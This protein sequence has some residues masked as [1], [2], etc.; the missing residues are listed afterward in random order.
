VA[1]VMAFP[2]LNADAAGPTP[3]TPVT[4]MAA[5]VK[6][7]PRCPSSTNAWKDPSAQTLELVPL[8]VAVAPLAGSIVQ[9]AADVGLNWIKERR[10]TLS[11]TTSARDDSTFYLER[12]SG[13]VA[14]NGCLI[15]ARGE[16]GSDAEFLRRQEARQF[17]SDPIWTGSRIR[18]LRN[19]WDNERVDQEGDIRRGRIPLVS[20]PMI[21]AEFSIRYDDLKHAKAFYL[22]PIFI[23]YRATSAERTSA[24]I[25]DL[26]FTFIF[27][28]LSS[29]SP[30]ARLEAHSPASSGGTTAQTE[31]AGSANP[32]GTF[33]PQSA[34]TPL[35]PS[36][37]VRRPPASDIAGPRS[38]SDQLRVAAKLD[39]VLMQTRIGSRFEADALIDI[40]SAL[41]PLPPWQG[42]SDEPSR[43]VTLVPVSVLATLTETEK[44]GNIELTLDNVIVQGKDSFSKTLGDVATKL[45]QETGK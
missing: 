21:Y 42:S 28:A 23:D 24:G 8:A 32:Q 13:A 16:L 12:D 29:G 36:S 19:G 1:V 11:A 10:D 33:S 34:S 18:L 17:D 25:K 38:G 37:V 31:A 45:L 9:I 27:E 44:A 30:V 43:P 3:N 5:A 20:A 40:V 14:R 6:L 7:V 15:F 39:V 26:A 2:V 22:K 41:Q 4:R 35:E